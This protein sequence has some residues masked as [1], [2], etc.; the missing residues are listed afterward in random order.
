[1][2]LIVLLALVAVGGVL[3]RTTSLLTAAIQPHVVADEASR[4]AALTSELDET[5]RDLRRRIELKDRLVADL[6]AGR[7]TMAEVTSQFL[8]MNHERP[9]Y[10][11]VVRF[12][13][14]GATDTEKAA[15][16]VIGY[17]EPEIAQYHP[18]HRVLVL[19]RLELQLRE[20]VTRESPD[21]V[22]GQKVRGTPKPWTSWHGE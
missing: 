15:R 9:E 12:H 16:N 2:A 13:Y 20:L 6:L 7:A 22:R 8:A 14:P 11:A 10:L 3:E 1:L 21:L 18:I 5:A 4:D 17:A 19:A